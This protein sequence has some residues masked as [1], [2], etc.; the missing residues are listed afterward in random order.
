MKK[1]FLRTSLSF[2]DEIA[3]NNTVVDRLNAYAFAHLSAQL[4]SCLTSG[5]ILLWRPAKHWRPWANQSR[6]PC[7]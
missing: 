3:A 5:R 7:G 1:G 4:K 2:L 6:R